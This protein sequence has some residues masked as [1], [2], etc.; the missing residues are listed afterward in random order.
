MSDC[1]KLNLPIARSTSK[2]CGFRGVSVSWCVPSSVSFHQ[3]TE[4]SMKILVS[5]GI[6]PEGAKILTDAG[7][8]VD[9]VKLTPDELRAILEMAIQMATIKNGIFHL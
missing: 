3:H 7:L 8:Q 1:V 6:S 2:G 9:N 5:D 4:H